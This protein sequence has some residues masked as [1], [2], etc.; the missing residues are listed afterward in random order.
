MSE[1]TFFSR[2][3]SSEDGRIRAAV[4]VAE[5]LKRHADDYDGNLGE[6]TRWAQ[7]LERVLLGVE[8]VDDM[9]AEF[10]RRVVIE[11]D[12]RQVST[13]SAIYRL[14]GERGSAIR[15]SLSRRIFENDYSGTEGCDQLYIRDILEAEGYVSTCPDCGELFLDESGNRTYSDDFVCE[16]CTESSYR[17]SDHHECYIHRDAC[18]RALDANGDRI[19]IHEEADGFSWDDERECLVH[20]DYDR[21]P[22][23]LIGDYHASK[24]HI[25]LKRDEWTAAYNRFL[26]VELEVECGSRDREVVAEALHQRVNGG[27]FGRAMFFE[28]D[29]SLTHGFEM[30]TQPMSVPALRDLFAFLR[31]SGD[32]LRGV[33][34]HRTQTCGLH[35][36]VSR[37]GLDNL[38]IARAVTFVNDPS[39]DAFVQALARRYNTGYCRVVEKELD[40]AHLPG[41]RYEA[42]NLTGRNT[43]EF[44][45]FRGSLKYEAVIAAV[46][47]CHA[48]LEYCARPS[49]SSSKLNARAF[50][51]F[52][53]D[54]LA[55]E[56]A[57]LRAYV[58]QRTAG[59]F[60]LSEAA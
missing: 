18:V 57:I 22:P 2:L 55:D 9:R 5:Q 51:E 6:F 10:V 48:I 33:T 36:H 50:L 23:P 16:S 4:F 24:E 34:S 43:I 58:E 37:T 12:G 21:G 13:P 8:G 31:E 11:A 42:V 15:Q 20:E 28:R 35:V 45:I 40:T 30:I 49:T 29:G 54:H 59:L 27:E 53:R 25:A 41:E 44:R 19:W 32:T 17:W 26:G 14:W 1:N 56:T 38:T 7:F 60:R 3:I 46:E 39:N 52:C 47:F